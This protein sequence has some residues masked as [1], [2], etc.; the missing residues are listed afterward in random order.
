MPRPTC[1]HAG[2]PC[3][4]AWP[5]ASSTCFF[6]PR[7]RPRPPPADT[8]PP[9]PRPGAF[10][11]LAAVAG[12][13]ALARPRGP[14][15]LSPF[16]PLPPP[17]GALSRPAAFLAGGS[18]PPSPTCAGGSPWP[19]PSPPGSATPVPRPSPAGGGPAGGG[20]SRGGPSCPSAAALAG[21]GGKVAGPGPAGGDGAEEGPGFCSGLQPGHGESPGPV[22]GTSPVARCWPAR[23]GVP[24]EA[25]D[26]PAGRAGRRGLV[27]GSFSC[28]CR[29]LV[30]VD[31][32]LAPPFALAF[33]AFG[34]VGVPGPP[35]FLR[36]CRL[37][38][39]PRGKPDACQDSQGPRAWGKVCRCLGADAGDSHA[40]RAHGGRRCGMSRQC[41]RLRAPSQQGNCHGSGQLGRG[42][43]LSSLCR[44]N[45]MMLA[46]CRRPAQTTQVMRYVKVAVVLGKRPVGVEALQQSVVGEGRKWTS[47]GIPF[48]V[49]VPG[50]TLHAAPAPGP[51]LAMPGPTEPAVACPDPSL[52]ASQSC[53]PDG[54]PAICRW[55]G[56]DRLQGGHPPRS[57]WQLHPTL[58]AGTP[59][60]PPAAAR[61]PRHPHTG[62]AGQW[63]GIP[64]TCTK[65]GF[66]QAGG[67]PASTR[68]A[69]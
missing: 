4:A 42:E 52:Q 11:G 8:G 18:L 58:P 9:A 40:C 25:P 12:W 49:Q 54:H 60:S 2:C 50:E 38:P 63:P 1:Q 28:S 32:G 41:A 35:P 19:C 27:K 7:P 16:A 65:V 20:V 5:G 33:A 15:P 57:R 43:K 6:P 24:G 64:A 55:H 30:G 39:H 21:R 68:H 48:D 23:G 36:S 69:G 51:A 3:P 47:T 44:A 29:P 10:A 62:R 13:S 26:P 37:H 61:R 34:F 14:A 22:P 17:L 46:L 45:T 56:P 66:S 59:G 67:R 53:G 31:F